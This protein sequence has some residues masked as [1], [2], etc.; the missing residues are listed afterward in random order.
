MIAGVAG[1]GQ[2]WHTSITTVTGG[3]SQEVII[4]K[5][6]LY[7]SSY[8]INDLSSAGVGGIDIGEAD[9]IGY[10]VQVTQ[11]SHVPAEAAYVGD[12][13][14]G[15]KSNL[16]LNAKARIVGH[17]LGAVPQDDAADAGGAPEFSCRSEECAVKRTPIKLLGVVNQRRITHQVA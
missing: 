13:K 12:V 15:P 7:E 6:R 9:A 8:T 4:Y 11:L 14:N 5:S 17:W 10:L 2:H 1:K 3:I 16:P